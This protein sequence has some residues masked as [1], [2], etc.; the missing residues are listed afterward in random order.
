[1]GKHFGLSGST[2]IAGIGK[3]LCG[4]VLGLVLCTEDVAA[5]TYYISPTGVDGNPGSKAQPWLTFARA[6]T[7]GMPKAGCGD[8][9]ILLDGVYGTGTS[10]GTIDIRDKICTASTVLTIRALNQR[11]ARIG[12]NGNMPL[13]PIFLYSANSNGIAYITIDGIVGN[14]ADN[15]APFAGDAAGSGCS[16]GVVFYV[17][18]GNHIQFKNVLARNVNR[19]CNVSPFV[20][21]TIN[22]SLVEDSEIYNYHR[23]GIV[24]KGANSVARRVYCN[25][26]IG[27]LASGYSNGGGVGNGDSCVTMYPCD[28]C[29]VE[30]IINDGTSAHGWISEVDA[31]GAGTDDQIL[32][33]IG[34]KTAANGI[35][36]NARGVGINFMPRNITIRNVVLYD[37]TGAGAGI[38][39]QAIKHTNVD[40]VTIVGQSATGTGVAAASVVPSYPGDSIYSFT[41]TNT[42]VTNFSSLG[43][44]VSGDYSNWTGSYLNAYATTGFFS[45]P[46]SNFTNTATVNPAL[47]T[48]VAW[49]PA[50]SPMKGAGSGGTDIGATI[51][52][53][54]Q[55]GVLTNVPLWNPTTGAFP[56]GAFDLDGVNAIAGNSLF[57][58]HTRINVNRNGCSFPAGYGTGSDVTA[59]SAPV[60]LSFTSN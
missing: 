51:L 49:I 36:I 47:G 21:D 29:I 48:C 40:H 3:S 57:D 1:M 45:F 34:Y 35:Y 4:L 28:F 52:Y 14:S 60:G 9:L 46:P 11:Q 13:A 7:T 12:D 24:L 50:G 42:L 2:V 32:G 56:H 10:T 15:I 33:S 37:H 41:I 22:N 16:T 5:M 31:L 59:P 6:L 18:N 54:Y 39:L 55:D 43:V 44:Y 23:H 26:R 19:Y 30:N 27:A 20:L 58:F 53:R 17:K 8:T 38:K 25:P